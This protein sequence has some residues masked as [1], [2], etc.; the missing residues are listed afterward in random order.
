ME[1]LDYKHVFK[2]LYS[3]KNT[4]PAEV[5][6]PQLKFLMVDGKGDPNTSQEYADAIQTL[7]P[8]AYTLKFMCKKELGKDYA[9]MPLEGLWWAE[10]MEA[11][12]KGDKGAWLWTAMIMQPDFVT[13]EMF[14]NAIVQVAQKKGAPSLDKIRLQAYEEGRAAQLMYT[15]PYAQEGPV[16]QELHAFIGAKGGTLSGDTKHHHEIYLSDPRRTAPEKLKTVIRQPF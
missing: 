6:V 7:Y 15:G 9:V 1:K 4:A 12:Q 3:P 5:Q 11:F 16:I 10:D 14:R 8:L 2:E 13:E